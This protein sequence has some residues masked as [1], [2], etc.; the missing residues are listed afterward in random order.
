MSNTPAQ[1]LV[2]GEMPIDDLIHLLQRIK[3]IDPNCKGKINRNILYFRTEN[4]ALRGLGG[5]YL[6]PESF[7]ELGQKILKHNLSKYNTN[8]RLL[9]SCGEGDCEP[10]YIMCPECI[11]NED[12]G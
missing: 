2:D 8:V 7:D 3:R 9:C 4:P 6:E 1:L 10:G 12:D 5:I 11:R